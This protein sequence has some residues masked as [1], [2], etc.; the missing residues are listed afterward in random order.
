M[1]VSRSIHGRLLVGVLLTA[2]T[3]TGCA[4]SGPNAEEESARRRANSHFNLAADHSD[5]GR[6]ELAMRELLAAKRL[7]PKNA[8]IQHA[9]GIAYLRKGKVPEAEA[10]LNTAIELAPGYHEAR[11]NLSTLYLNQGR[12]E[13]CVTHSQILFDDPTFSSPWRAL[14]NWG[15]S[16]YKLGDRAQ[17]RSHL[18]Y[19]RDY[20]HTYWPTHLNLG[21]LEQEE[22]NRGAAIEAFTTVLKLRPDPSAAAEANYR[23]AEIYVSMGRRREAMGHLRTAVVKAPND[24]WGKKSEAYLKRLR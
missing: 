12:Y 24:P 6:I 11:Y 14:T 10:H 21:I 17:A 5:N 18:E 9:L 16:A 13:E 15:W 1:R 2:L 4:T 3:A 23:L 19:A 7:D 20:N 22:G 8:K